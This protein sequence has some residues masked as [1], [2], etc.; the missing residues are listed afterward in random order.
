[1][2]NDTYV[3]YYMAT[4]A[5]KVV[6]THAHEISGCIIISRIIY[7]RA[8]HIGG[9]NGDVQSDPP[10]SFKNGEQL[11][12]SHRRI[13][14]LQQEIN[15]S[16]ETVPPTILLFQYMKA[17]SKSENFKAFIAPKMT[18]IVTLP[19]NNVKYAVYTGGNIHGLYRYLDIIGD[20]TTLT[21]PSQ[22]SNHI[23]ISSS[24][25]NYT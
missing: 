15:L 6:S 7:S 18:D 2:T 12:Y 13:I 24:I 5:Y 17:L 9:M 25:N 11:E 16:G 8:P 4:Q 14:R 23:G 3:K 1:M 20:P 22:R 21:T 19:D 10:R